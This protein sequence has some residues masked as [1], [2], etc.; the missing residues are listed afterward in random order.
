MCVWER[1]GAVIWWFVSGNNWLPDVYHPLERGYLSHYAWH[2]TKPNFTNKGKKIPP[3]VNYF[4]SNSTS[5]V[6]FCRVLNGVIVYKIPSVPF[7]KYLSFSSPGPFILFQKP[8]Q[9]T[10]HFESIMLYL[11]VKQD[12]SDGTK[13]CR[14]FDLNVEKW[15]CV[16]KTLNETRSIRFWANGLI[17][18]S[19]IQLTVEDW[20]SGWFKPT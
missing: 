15:A 10:Q 13:C 11:G 2:Y 9:M 14:E 7:L 5:S 8:V 3:P 4:I 16:T 1:E 12:R 6:D 20:V 19:S 17:V 18:L